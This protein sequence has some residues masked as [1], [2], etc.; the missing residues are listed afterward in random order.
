LNFYIFIILEN[1][2][3][4]YKFDPMNNNLLT[5]KAGSLNYVENRQYEIYAWTNYLDSIYS[6]K[7]RIIIINVDQLPVVL[8]SYKAFNIF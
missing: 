7:I 2:K 1:K 6:Q 5:L 3:D 4:D 8:I